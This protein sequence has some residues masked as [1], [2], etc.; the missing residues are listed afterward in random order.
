[1]IIN[2]Y[3]KEESDTQNLN[4]PHLAQKIIAGCSEYLGYEQ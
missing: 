4:I 2:D 3:E 1:M